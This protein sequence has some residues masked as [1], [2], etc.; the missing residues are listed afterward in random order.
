MASWWGSARRGTAVAVAALA[1]LPAASAAHELPSSTI[2]AFTDPAIGAPA[3]NDQPATMGRFDTPCAEP[4]ID[5]RPTNDKC[6]V[7]DCSSGSLFGYDRSL[8]C[9]PDGVSVNVLPGSRVM[10]YDGL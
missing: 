3:N 2:D 6:V 7:K 1:T 9:K 10:Y 5:G 4:A 8:D